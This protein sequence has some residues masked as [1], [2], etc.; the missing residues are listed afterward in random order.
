MNLH[1]PPDRQAVYRLNLFYEYLMELNWLATHTNVL[2]LDISHRLTLEAGSTWKWGGVMV[3]NGDPPPQWSWIVSLSPSFCPPPLLPFLVQ[4]TI[5]R[6][7]PYEWEGVSSGRPNHP[8]SCQSVLY[9]LILPATPTPNCPRAAVPLSPPLSR[10]NLITASVP[11]SACIPGQ[12]VGT[13]F[14]LLTYECKSIS[15]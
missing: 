15:D 12:V 10:S 1:W 4:P 11:C 8:P 9:P 13:I 7:P 6:H 3:G 5:I 2:V 14:P